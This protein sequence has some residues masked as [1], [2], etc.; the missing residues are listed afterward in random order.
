MG[1]GAGGTIQ[2]YQLLAATPRP[3]VIYA[4]CIQTVGVPVYCRFINAGA[5]CNTGEIAWYGR[6]THYNAETA[7]YGTHPV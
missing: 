5:L 2:Q 3:P 4:R 6:G 1:G 7:L